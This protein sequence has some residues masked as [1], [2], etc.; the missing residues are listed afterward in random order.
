MAT[1]GWF[2]VRCVLR[3][4]HGTRSTYEERVTLWRAART[5]DAIVLAE[6]EAA[7]YAATVSAEY[8]GLAQAYALIGEPGHG[9]EIFSLMR[10]SD[11][12]PDDYLDAFFDTGEERQAG[13]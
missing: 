12:P 5:D 11:L 6:S 2:S 1:D 4:A 7:D 3:F 10:D 8:A 9:A 13:W